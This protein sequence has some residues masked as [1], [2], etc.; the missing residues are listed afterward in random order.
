MIKIIVDTREPGDKVK[1]LLDRIMSGDRFKNIEIEY[2]VLKYGDYFIMNGN[3]TLLIE[4][5]EVHD[6]VNSYGKGKLR[7]KLFMMKTKL[8]YAGDPHF[9]DDFTE[10]SPHIHKPI[11]RAMLLIEGHYITKIGDPDIYLPREGGIRSVLK[12]QTYVNFL[13]SQCEKGTWIYFTNN[14]WETLLTVLYLAENLENIQNP[15]HSLKCGNPRELLV[16]IPGIGPETLKK[17][18]DQYETPLEALANVE[19]W[20]N[21]T[22]K[23]ALKSWQ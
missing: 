18:Q 14:L 12:L 6:F 4:R 22:V 8:N 19:T 9:L 7:E 15:K 20:G 21:K 16:Q 13:S 17:L 11:H 2:K 3:S 23:E 10:E 1:L 5:K